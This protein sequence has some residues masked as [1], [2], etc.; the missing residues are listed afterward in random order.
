[1]KNIKILC[2]V[3]AEELDKSLK[4]TSISLSIRN[5]N[6]QMCVE[7]KV[8]KQ[9]KKKKYFLTEIIKRAYFVTASEIK[10]ILL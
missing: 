3:I 6:T 10:I 8:D 5:I 1:M 4:K 7:H 2:L 9:N